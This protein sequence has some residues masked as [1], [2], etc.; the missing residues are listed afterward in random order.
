MIRDQNARGI[1]DDLVFI[2]VLGAT[3]EW[4]KFTLSQAFSL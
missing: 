3:D 1:I 4:K 2:L